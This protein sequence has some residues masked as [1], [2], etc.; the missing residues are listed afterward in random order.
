[1]SDEVTKSQKR[2]ALDVFMESPRSYLSLA[3]AQLQ[4]LAF[5]GSVEC[6]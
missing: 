4:F 5:S 1:M 2:L 3:T 6:S